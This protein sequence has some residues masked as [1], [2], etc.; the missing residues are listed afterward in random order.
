MD[1]DEVH[2]AQGWATGYFHSL[3]SR[4]SMLPRLSILLGVSRVGRGHWLLLEWGLQGWGEGLEVMMEVGRG[5][6][7]KIDSHSFGL[8]FLPHMKQPLSPV[9]FGG[10]FHP[11]Q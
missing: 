2:R 6:G 7:E 1:T 5:T 11:L 10:R 4:S 3:E 8:P 9:V